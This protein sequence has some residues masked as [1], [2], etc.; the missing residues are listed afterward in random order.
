MVKKIERH[1]LES[2]LDWK[3]VRKGLFTASR[4]SDILAD[5]R[6]LMNETELAEYKKANPKSTAKYKED[7]TVLSEGAITY[8]LEIIQGLEGAE[9]PQYY[10]QAMQWGT[11]TEPDAVQRYC[12]M[13]GHDL[14]SDDV[15][16]TSIGGVV[17][18]VGDNILGCTPDLILPDR[19]VQV[20]CPDSNTHL[21]YKLHV[22][23]LNF[24]SE[25]P[26]YYAQVQLEMM[27]TER[28]IC[29]FFSF[30]PRF[31]RQSLQ[32]LTITIQADENFQNK[33]YRKAVLCEAK[34]QEYIKLIESL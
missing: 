33:I 10:N 17:F 22:N 18:F 34:K 24:K 27:L 4:I 11:D 15:I 8:I 14:L 20:K 3:G 31:S 12:E 26:N 2:K 29:D 13:Y 9:K 5:G 1:I 30:D 16:Y 23:E 28:K 32:T 7:E 19:V 6:V 25:L 21:Y